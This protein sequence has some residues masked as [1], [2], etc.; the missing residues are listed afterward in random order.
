ML[1]SGL[2]GPR[3]GCR[4][5]HTAWVRADGLV[6]DHKL[7]VLRKL[8]RAGLR[9]VMIG[10]ER[11]RDSD[12][13]LL[14]KHGQSTETTREALAILRQH[15]PEVYTI[16]SMIFGLPGDSDSDLRRM[17]R[18]QYRAGIDYCFLI[19]LTPNAGTEMTEALRR[20]GHIAS[21]DRGTYNFHTPV[22]RTDHLDLRQ[23][24]SVYWRLIN[25]ADLRWLRDAL[26][27][28]FLER[29]RRKRRLHRALRMKGLTIA[30]RAL[31]RRVLHPRDPT[32]AVFSRRPSWYES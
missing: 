20:S 11:D 22:C 16:G 14:A 18:F 9:Q 23:L 25:A 1:A 5:L 12:L 29:D 4:T 19:P 21:S 27:G 8:V 32:P 6:R 7:G 13:A 2:C 3:S 24:E 17:M 28:M 26:K 15:Y 10:V 31:A 30:A